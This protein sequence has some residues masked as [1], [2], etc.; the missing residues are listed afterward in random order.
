MALASTRS[1]TEMRTKNIPGD[2]RRPERKADKLTAIY[3]P[4]FQ[5]QCGSLDV[6][7]FYGPSRPVTGRVLPSH[8]LTS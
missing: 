4:I 5:T 1:L 8:K 7:Q 3:D 6:S 2:K